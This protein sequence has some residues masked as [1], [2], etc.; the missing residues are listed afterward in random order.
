[1]S[2]LGFMYH[3][4]MECELCMLNIFMKPWEHTGVLPYKE[5]NE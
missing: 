2:A 4:G 5:K 3:L 1:M